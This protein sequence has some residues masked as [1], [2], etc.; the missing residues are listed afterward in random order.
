VVKVWPLEE[1]QPD[2]LDTMKSL[3][4]HLATETDEG[5]VLGL[6]ATIRVFVLGYRDR[7]SARTGGTSRKEQQPKEKELVGAVTRL[8]VEWEA[9]RRADEALL[10]EERLADS[11][12][13][14][15]EA[16]T[17]EVDEPVVSGQAQ[18]IILMLVISVENVSHFG[19]DT[20]LRKY[21]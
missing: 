19:S 4:R 20:T 21:F 12:E 6:L 17:E 1:D 7:M 10:T 18:R 14:P 9:K 8:V 11:A 15:E 5:Q 2:L 16:T 3:V 13:P